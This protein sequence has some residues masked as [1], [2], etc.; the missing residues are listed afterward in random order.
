MSGGLGQAML[1][2]AGGDKAG[3]LGHVEAA[4]TGHGAGVSSACR[5]PNAS[6]KR[7]LQTT[8]AALRPRRVWRAQVGTPLGAARTVCEGREDTELFGLDGVHSSIGSGRAK[9]S[10]EI[11]AQIR[12]LERVSR[13]PESSGGA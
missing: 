12:S 13:N 1:S 2:T 5:W 10:S 8:L 4:A 9:T 3:R 11:G 7:G 6:S